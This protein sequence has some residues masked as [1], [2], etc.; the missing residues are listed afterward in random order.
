MS[1]LKTHLSQLLSDALLVVAPEAQLPTIELSRT[2][3]ESHGDFACNI[4]MPLA[5]Q[6]KR[7]PRDVA[8]AIQDALPNSPWVDKTEIAGAGF[9][10]FFLNNASKQ[11]VVTEILQQGQNFGRAP[12]LGKRVQV[13]FVS[14]NPT[15][16][17]HVGHGRG[18][19]FGASLT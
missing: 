1:D 19:A 6:L 9:I 13:E 7:N 5:K 2:K 10:N 15:G 8:K 3:Q 4:A 16:P 18:A 14:A 11:R 12:A 17:L